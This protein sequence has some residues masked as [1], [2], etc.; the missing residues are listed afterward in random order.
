MLGAVVVVTAVAALVAHNAYQRP[1]T[2]AVSS[3]APVVVAPESTSVPST[4]EPGPT[5]V[6]VTP[7]VARFPLANQVRQALQTYFDSVN[8]RSYKLWRSVVTPGLAN[9]KSASDF[10]RGYRTTR[11]GSIVLYR[12]DTTLDNGL[13]V[14]LTFHS[15]QSQ[16]DA[17]KGFPHACIVW[18]LVWP[19]TFDPD[20][21]A[22]KVDAGTTDVSTKVQAC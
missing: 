6:S 17:P 14:L 11:D 4:E 9:T 15:T 10:E 16:A 19:L 20:D 2:A 12:V 7:D 1:T 22:W 18:H 5:T 8:M 3:P 13:R 21:N